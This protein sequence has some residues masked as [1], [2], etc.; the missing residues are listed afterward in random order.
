MLHF[1]LSLEALQTQTEKG[2]I[3]P[4]IVTITDTFVNDTDKIT[5]DDQYP[6]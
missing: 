4:H 6:C 2:G 3:L 1:A 5:I